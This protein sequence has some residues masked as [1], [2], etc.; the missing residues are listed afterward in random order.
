MEAQD[1]GFQ[2]G[3]A[4]FLSLLTV[5]DLQLCMNLVFVPNAETPKPPLN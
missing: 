4:N 5:H 3:V 2:G 1:H